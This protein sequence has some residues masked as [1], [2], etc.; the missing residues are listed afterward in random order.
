MKTTNFNRRALRHGSIATIL[1]VIFIIAVI[2]VNVFVTAVANRFNTTLDLTPNSNFTISEDNEEFIRQIDKD[3]TITVAL[4]EEQYISDGENGYA[5]Y[6]YQNGIQDQTY[7]KYFVQASEILKRYSKINP[8]IK[9]EYKNP[10]SPSFND[11]AEKYQNEMWSLGDYFVECSFVNSKGE[12]QTRYKILSIDDLF[13]LADESGYAAQGYGSYTIG[14]SKVE[15][16]VTSALYYVTAER[17]DYVTIITGYGCDT[18]DALQ[19]AMATENYEFSTMDNLVTDTIPEDTNILV[20]AAPTKDM[21]VEETKI[22]DKWLTGDD[23]KNLIYF[24]SSKQSV[25]PNIE[26]MLSRWGIAFE[27]GTVYETGDTRN[28]EINT[29]MLVEDSGSKYTQAINET[30]NMYYMDEIRPMKLNFEEHG[31]YYTTSILQSY[32]TTLI[33]PKGVKDDWKPEKGAPTQSYQVMA[34]STYAKNK[35]SNILAIASVDMVSEN[36]MSVSYIANQLAVEQT[37]SAM[38]LRENNIYDF[39][40]KT[41]DASIFVSTETHKSVSKWVCIAGIPGLTIILGILIYIWRK[42]K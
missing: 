37:V 4:S 42:R 27:S 13:E 24:A 35:P 21:T 38:V 12:E 14:N 3:V 22:I 41:I 20:L 34:M 36:Y 32:N 8:N 16:A 29:L 26:D 1:T 11:F 28:A 19:S 30:D 18:V 31:K 15:S 5:A 6:L 23:A 9:V 10:N 7:G 40:P 39:T 33:K 17:T 2:L 25:L